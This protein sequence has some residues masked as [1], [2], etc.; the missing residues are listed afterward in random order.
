MEETGV[1]ISTDLVKWQR[2]FDN[3]VLKIGPTGE[4][5]DLFA[6]DPVVLRHND[7][8]IMFYFGNCSDGHARDGV[9]F[10]DDLLHWQKGNKVLVDVGQEGSIDSKHACKPGIISKD[11][12]L[13]H[14]YCAVSPAGDKH[15]G[16]I[17]HSEVR[18]I[19]LAT[20]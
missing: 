9:V 6:S 17:E 1:A 11:G 19:T 2:Y 13:Y 16:E 5:D 15:L 8:W 18:G 20:S 4:F 10:S 3:P 7:I 14:F 12:K